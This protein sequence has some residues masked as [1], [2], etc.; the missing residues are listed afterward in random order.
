MKWFLRFFLG[1]LAVV[2]LLAGGAYFWVTRPTFQKRML[3]RNLPEGGTV[4]RVRVR[5]GSLLVSGLEVPLPDGT[6]VTVAKA[7][8]TFDLWAAL[9]DRTVKLGPTTVEGLEITLPERGDGRTTA[10]KAVSRA[11]GGRVSGWTG[12]FS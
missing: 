9:T 12:G 3:E 4:E 6:R 7:E 1:A 11:S 5:P 8:N 2:L 10:A